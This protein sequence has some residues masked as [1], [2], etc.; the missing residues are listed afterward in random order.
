MDPGKAASSEIL[1]GYTPFFRLALCYNPRRKFPMTF[2][3]FY[4]DTPSHHL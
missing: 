2:P 4:A 3:S 1:N